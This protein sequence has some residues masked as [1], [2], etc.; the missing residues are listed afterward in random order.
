VDDLAGEVVLSSKLERAWNHTLL[1][2][3]P[4]GQQERALA[5]LRPRFADRELI[6]EA[7]QKP[8]SAWDV[9]ASDVESLIPGMAINTVS[10]KVLATFVRVE[11]YQNDLCAVVTYKGVIKGRGDLDENQEELTTY[12]L[13]LTSYRSLTIGV[14]LRT[15]G[16]ITMKQTGTMI[17]EGDDVAFTNRGR[18]AFSSTV[19]VVK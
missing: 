12:D 19:T 1:E 18:L 16:D 9:V 7:K 6:P 13:N 11:P 5:R 8:G 15:A 17:F 3:T 14:N 10:G 4:T 2:H